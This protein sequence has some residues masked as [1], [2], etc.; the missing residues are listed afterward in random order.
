MRTLLTVVAVLSGAAA[1]VARGQPLQADT[2]VS[3]G[4]I[5]TADSPDPDAYH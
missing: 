5:V 2:V 1:P 3:G 4:K